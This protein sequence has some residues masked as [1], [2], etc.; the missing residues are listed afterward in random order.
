MMASYIWYL[1]LI[2]SVVLLISFGFLASKAKKA[3]RQLNKLSRRTTRFIDNLPQDSPKYQKSDLPSLAEAKANRRAE[4]SRRTKNRS[5]RQ[6][7]LVEHLKDLQ[8]K[9]SE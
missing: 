9:E 6:R 4:V 1:P 7:R 5:A 2:S 3:Q 8:A